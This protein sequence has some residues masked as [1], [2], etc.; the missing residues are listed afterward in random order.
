MRQ[1]SKAP[2]FIRIDTEVAL[3]LFKKWRHKMISGY[4]VVSFGERPVC[5]SPDVFSGSRGLW[6]LYSKKD[7]LWIRR[8]T[9]DRVAIKT[10][11]KTRLLAAKLSYTRRVRHV[12]PDDRMPNLTECHSSGL[13]EPMTCR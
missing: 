13:L 11:C 4:N 6:L 7:C 8:L 1:K 2:I 10:P 3:L 5:L 12:E 9:Y